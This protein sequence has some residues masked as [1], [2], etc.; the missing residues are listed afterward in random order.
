[1]L[2]SF[3]LLY[4]LKENWS[5]KLSITLLPG[6]NSRWREENE[7]KTSLNLLFMFTTW[8]I[9]SSHWYLV[10]NPSKD[11]CWEINEEVEELFGSMR[12]WMIWLG[13]SECI[14]S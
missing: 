14:L 7:G 4:K 11:K 13:G 1:M 9:I 3:L 2:L 5:E 6:V 12:E 10:R 8:L